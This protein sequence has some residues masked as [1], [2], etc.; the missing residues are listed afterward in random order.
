MGNKLVLF[1]SPGRVAEPTIPL[2]LEKEWKASVSY[3][4]GGSSESTAKKIQ[5]DYGNQKIR[6]IEADIS[7]LE[8]SKKFLKDSLIYFGNGLERIAL[9]NVASQFPKK[10]DFEKWTQEKGI[11]EKDWR[12]FNSNFEVMRNM[13]LAVLDYHK[14]H[15]ELRVDIVNF[16]DERSQRYFNENLIHPFSDLNKKT[17]EITIEDA[18]TK[19]LDLLDTASVSGRDYNPYLLSKLLI[20]YMTREIALDYKGKNVRVNAIAP[21]VMS[22]SPNDT[23]EQA[24][25]YARQSTITGALEGH[26][27]AGDSIYYL[28]E[29]ASN[30]T[31]NILF[32]D[33][34]MHLLW[35]ENNQK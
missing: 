16:A 3:R 24:E 17:L 7:S 1:A 35:V 4:S 21:G 20:G 27:I 2:L 9:I 25:E 32:P 33:G 23:K 12:Y 10:E 31:G 5:Q 29:M 30:M 15:P 22:A 14:S 6:A 8:G 18:K 11:D 28:L 13:S 19:G 34:G 26:K